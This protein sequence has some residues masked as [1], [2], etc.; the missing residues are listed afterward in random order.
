MSTIAQ[1]SG[2]ELT[3]T[4]LS[5]NLPTDL[6]KVEEKEMQDPFGLL[7]NLAIDGSA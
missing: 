4:Q 2:S 5:L 7:S 6:V 3:V 1:S